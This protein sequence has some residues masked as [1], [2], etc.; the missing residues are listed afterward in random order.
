LSSNITP[1]AT[2]SK[3]LVI[4]NVQHYQA[5]SGGV[6]NEMHLRLIETNSS[7][8]TGIQVERTYGYSGYGVLHQGETT[9]T[10]LHSP[11][12]TSQRTYA[13]Q[14]KYQSGTTPVRIQDTGDGTIT[15][16]EIDGS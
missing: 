14:W 9:L 1:S 15:L 2:T 10:W 8:T 16:L 3:I 13:V 4:A 11:S 5:G 12:T 6:D 7:D